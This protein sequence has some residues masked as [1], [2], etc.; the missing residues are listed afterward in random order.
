MVIVVLCI[1]KK[2]TV[3]TEFTV[4]GAVVTLILAVED[5]CQLKII[6]T[7]RNIVR[8]VNFIIINLVNKW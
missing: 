3:S 8:L 5:F 6:H 7:R 4:I 2:L 1:Y